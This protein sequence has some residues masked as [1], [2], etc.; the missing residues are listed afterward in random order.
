MFLEESRLGHRPRRKAL[1]AD[2]REVVSAAD[3]V[4]SGA[5]DRTYDHNRRIRSVVEWS[6]EDAKKLCVR[7]AYDSPGKVAL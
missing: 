1:A 7:Y 4:H 2:M 6:K 3:Q 5:R